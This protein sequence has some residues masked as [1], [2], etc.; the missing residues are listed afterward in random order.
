MAR[1]Q[2]VKRAWVKFS[3]V[4][5][6]LAWPGKLRGNKFF[7]L[8]SKLTG[9]PLDEAQPVISLYVTIVKGRK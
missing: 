3:E 6:S 4:W 2:T 5:N 1:K 8:P 7:R 9:Q